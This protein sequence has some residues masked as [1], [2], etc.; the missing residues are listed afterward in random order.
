MPEGDTIH[1]L[2]RYLA[3]RLCGQTL[4]D[5][6]LRDH[7]GH[8]LKGRRVDAVR[9][10]GKHL[11]IELDDGRLLRSHLGM[12]GSWHHYRSGEAWEKPTYQAAIV[13]QLADEVFVCF[14]PMQTEVLRTGQRGQHTLPTALGPDLLALTPPF[15]ELPARARSLLP[16]ATPLADVLL[17][18]RVAAGI[19]NVYKSE[20]LFLQGLHPLYPLGQATD[21]QLVAL[22][23]KAAEL[24]RANLGPGPRVTRRQAVAGGPLWVYGRRGMPCLRCATPIVQ[25]RLGRHLRSTYWCPACQ[26]PAGIASR[27]P[28][29]A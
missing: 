23:R 19:G 12:T 29:G 15:D 17:D 6:C 26:P 7:P 20:V 28:D 14:N 22:Y 4:T 2:A 16:S 11:F 3:Q 24:L 18:Q 9:A 25:A 13:L 27:H 10:H 1:K 8:I 21:A 5:A